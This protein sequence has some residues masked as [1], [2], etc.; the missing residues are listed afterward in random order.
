[1][2]QRIVDKHKSNWHIMLFPAL[3]AYRTLVKTAT[4]FTPFHLVHGVE[5]IFPIE[6][7]IPSLKLVVEL[8]PNTS[9]EEERL[10][11]LSQLDEYRRASAM[12]NESHKKCIKA[13]CDQSVRRQT[14]A[15]GDLVFLYDQD[16]DILGPGKF[17]PMWHGPYTIKHVLAKGA[18]ELVDHEGYYL[19]E[20]RNGLYLKWYFS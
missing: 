9:A 19:R 11:Y 13:Q 15:V 1:M 3:W 17:K 16:H 10:L 2:L 18:Y 4:G 5:S 8:L 12:V 7:E 14:F 20:P 6:Y